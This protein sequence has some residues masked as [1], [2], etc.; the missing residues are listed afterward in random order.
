MLGLDVW[1]E[2]YFVGYACVS[3]CN[4]RKNV[5]TGHHTV[6]ETKFDYLGKVAFGSPL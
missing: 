3:Y 1:G 5:R 2:E 6:N 4:I